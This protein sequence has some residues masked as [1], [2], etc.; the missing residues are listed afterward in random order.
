MAKN[1]AEI[2]PKTKSPHF[3]TEAFVDR[4]KV[5]YNNY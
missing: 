1:L 2:V 4:N 5:F 3:Y